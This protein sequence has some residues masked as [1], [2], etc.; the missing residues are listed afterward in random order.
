M[1]FGHGQN[2]VDLSFFPFFD[3]SASTWAHCRQVRVF[4]SMLGRT[5][6]GVTM[7]LFVVFSQLLDT[8]SAGNG[9]LTN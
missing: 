4:T 3:L 1:S 5:K 2:E 8:P 6:R 9:Q 7:T